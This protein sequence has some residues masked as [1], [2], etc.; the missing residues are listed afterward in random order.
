MA[1]SLVITIDTEP[2]NQW[3][4][5]SGGSPPPLTFANTRGLSRLIESLR[6]WG[7]PATWLTCYSVARDPESA[8]LLREAAR[9]GDEIGAHL[10]AWETPPLTGADARAHPYIYEY[11]PEIRSAKLASLTGVLADTFGAAPRSHRAGRWGI[12]DQEH[13]HLAEAGYRIDTSVVPGFDFG[14]SIGLSRGGPDFRRHLDGGIPTPHREGQLW[15]VPV[16]TTTVGTLGS[17]SAP[18]A[19][20]RA[21]HGRSPLPA[22]AARKALEVAGLSR[23]VWLRP[24]AHPREHLV[25]A[26]RAVI[27]RGVPIVNV[28]FHSSEA[29]EGTSPRSRT[30]DDVE[31]FYA[32][33]EA[34]VRE[35]ARPGGATPR[36]L[37][38][39]LAAWSAS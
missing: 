38:G 28:M 14:P 15:E 9:D 21:L 11:D 2:D 36:T 7:T 39:A 16:T 6:R 10:H 3:V 8:G 33:M 25:R 35:V 17:G 13:R 23:L 19:L 4:M 18:A 24:L 32:D 1:P 31:R 20:A 37:S 27:A 5:P 12:D 29:F 22:R 26:A 34:I 30:R